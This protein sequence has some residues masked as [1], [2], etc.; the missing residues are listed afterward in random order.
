MKRR[1]IFLVAGG[2]ALVFAIVGGIA[3][4]LWHTPAF[5]SETLRDDSSVEMRE[6][7]SRK[8]VQ[9]ATQLETSIKRDDRWAGEFSQDQVNGFLAY[10][11]P[12]RFSGL[13][14]EQAG[15]PR[16]R[17]SDDT[18]DLA[19]RYHHGWWKG[20]VHVQ[21]RPYVLGPS[22]IG[23]DVRTVRAG[24]VPIPVADPLDQIVKEMR[25]AGW[26]VQ[27]RPTKN[28]EL[29]VIDLEPEIASKLSLDGIE[30]RD[31]MLRFAGHRPSPQVTAAR[32]ASARGEAAPGEPAD[33]HSTTPGATAAKPARARR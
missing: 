22:Q 25:K 32:A 33:S 21:V 26:L 6:K 28:G 3:T 17:F 31:G 16:V 14:P 10:D 1:R 5:Y 20:T 29:L 11:V 19:F 4:A 7:Q 12:E 2:V 8:F 24:A 27:W 23:L 18:I 15:D 30:L 9:L 13:L